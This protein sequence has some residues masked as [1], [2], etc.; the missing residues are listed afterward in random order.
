MD[1]EAQ[2]G[3]HNSLFYY[4]LRA[5]C[6]EAVQSSLGTVEMRTFAGTGFPDPESGSSYQDWLTITSS[7]SHS[8]FVLSQHPAQ[9]PVA[10]VRVIE[11][12]QR[13]SY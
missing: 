9:S 11:A 10:P 3:C 6:G 13:S 4:R 5:Q 1:E 8:L 7:S 2:R 12:H